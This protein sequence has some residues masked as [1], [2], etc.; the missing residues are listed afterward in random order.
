VPPHIQHP[1]FE[2]LPPA[3]RI[4]FPKKSDFGGLFIFWCDDIARLSN[5]FDISGFFPFCEAKRYKNDH[6][7]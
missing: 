6:H 3:V 7:E 4:A 1:F 2:T 5:T